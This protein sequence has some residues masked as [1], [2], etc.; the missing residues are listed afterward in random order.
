M[1]GG[2]RLFKFAG[3]AVIGFVIFISSIIYT[4]IINVKTSDYIKTKGIVVNVIIEKG[5][6]KISIVEY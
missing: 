6:N 2:T 1:P 5:I 3:F 4:I